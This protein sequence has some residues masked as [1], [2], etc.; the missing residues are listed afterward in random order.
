ML[1]SKLCFV[2]MCSSTPSFQVNK[3]FQD[4]IFH[5]SLDA[6]FKTSFRWGVFVVVFGGWLVCLVVVSLGLA[7]CCCCWAWGVVIHLFRVFCLVCCC[8]VFVFYFVL[9]FNVKV[10]L[11]QKLQQKEIQASKIPILGFWHVKVNG[12]NRINVRYTDQLICTFI[13]DHTGIAFLRKMKGRG[14][15]LYFKENRGRDF[16]YC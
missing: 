9:F 2:G 5:F 4:V 12:L 14:V 3:S 11:T 7:F 1:L 10:S 13:L 6:F 15:V 16:A 8:L